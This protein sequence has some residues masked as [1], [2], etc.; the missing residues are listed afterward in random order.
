MHTK[1]RN[2]GR[3]DYFLLLV[4][5]LGPGIMA[6]QSKTSIIHEGHISFNKAPFALRS[7]GVEAKKHLERLVSGLHLQGLYRHICDSQ[8]HEMPLYRITASAI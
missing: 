5:Q 4:V 2:F 8:C 6:I 1:T 7:G 3:K